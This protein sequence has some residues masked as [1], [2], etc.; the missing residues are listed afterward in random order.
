MTFETNKINKNKVNAKNLYASRSHIRFVIA[1]LLF[2]RRKI[3]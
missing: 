2:A 1:K 3:S